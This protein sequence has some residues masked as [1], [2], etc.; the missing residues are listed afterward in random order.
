[1]KYIWQQ[2]QK[3]HFEY[4]LE[5]VQ[6]ILYQYAI[7]TDFLANKHQL[8]Q[9]ARID[10]TIELMAEQAVKS[11]EIEGDKIDQEE[12]RSSIKN[13]LGRSKKI[14][15]IKDPRAA[16]IAQL[17]LSIRKNYQKPLTAKSAVGPYF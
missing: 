9:D 4:S 8:P 14:E 6:D 13:Q 5:P 10:V 17:M 15:L 1:M 11:S 7:A 12:V 2:K 3:P 16:G